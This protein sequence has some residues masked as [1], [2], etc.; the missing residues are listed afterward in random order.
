MEKIKKEQE[1][2]GY[3]APTLQIIFVC[4]EDVI[5]T[6]SSDADGGEYGDDWL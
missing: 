3:E 6:S 1:R 5:R 4:G 2:F